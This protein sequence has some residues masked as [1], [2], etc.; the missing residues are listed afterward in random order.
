MS[1]ARYNASRT[2]RSRNG[3]RPPHVRARHLREALVEAEV[4]DPQLRDL[5]QPHARRG[6][7]AA[8]LPGR[9][10]LGEVG[11][12]AQQRRRALAPVGDRDPDDPVHGVGPLLEAP[13]VGVADQHRRA[14]RPGGVEP[15]RAGAHR[16]VAGVGA[17]VLVVGRRL[18]CLVLARPAGR[19]DAGGAQAHR[20]QQV[21]AARADLDRRRAGREHLGDA[22]EVGLD[23]GGRRACPV[24]AEDDVPGG[25][26]RAVMEAH[27]RPQLEPPPIPGRPA[28]RRRRGW[29]AG[30]GSGRRR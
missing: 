16:V 11:L 18:R 12:A 24:E 26:G 23:R 28:P 22:A 15:E 21:G 29:V 1:I 17:G 30:R 8:G 3:L 20:Q 7:E 14:A 25:E 6:P 5:G 9:Q 19:H 10:V 4:R 13:P 27:A 2:R